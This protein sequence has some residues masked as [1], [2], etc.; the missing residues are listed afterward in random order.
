[1]AE[2]ARAAAPGGDA[3]QRAAD[4]GQAAQRG[5]QPS[6]RP[7]V[8]EP[9]DEIEPRLDRSAIGQRR[10]DRRRAAARRRR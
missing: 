5:A 3:A 9:A 6:R 8:V 2:V 7:L 4:I 10:A 1:L